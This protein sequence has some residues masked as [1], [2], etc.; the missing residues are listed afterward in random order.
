MSA[1]AKTK[2]EWAE[3]KTR[4]KAQGKQKSTSGQKVKHARGLQSAQ[5]VGRLS[6]GLLS[7]L[8]LL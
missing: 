4:V 1:K 2:H 3:D 5:G 8:L 7:L 6:S